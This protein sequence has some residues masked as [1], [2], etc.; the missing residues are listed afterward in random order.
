V[1]ISV[2]RLTKS[3]KKAK[4]RAIKARMD[5]NLGNKGSRIRG[6]R[7]NKKM[8]RVSSMVAFQTID[9]MEMTMMRINDLTG[10]CHLSLEMTSQTYRQ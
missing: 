8:K 4:K 10:I 9:P 7:N 5:P 2:N 1:L 3:S 6:P